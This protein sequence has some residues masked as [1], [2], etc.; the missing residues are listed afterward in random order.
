MAFSGSDY[1]NLKFLFAIAAA[2][3]AY[4]F[5]CAA[6]CGSR[7][8]N[9]PPGPPTL[10]LLG[11]LTVMPRKRLHLKFSEWAKVY[12]DVFSLKVLNQTIIVINSPTLVRELIDKRSA[13]T[14]NRPKSILA[15]MITPHNM[16]MGT[17]H[18]AN[19]TW[20]SMRKASAQ[21]LSNENMRAL[22][23]YQRA[24][25]TQLMWELAHVPEDWF[26]HM[27]RY[28]TSFALGIIYGKRGPTLSSQDVADFMDVHP[29]FIHAL[30]IGTMPPVDLFPVLTLVPER[31]ASW[32]T[33]VKNIRH[34]HE[35][36]YDRL[37]TTV[38]K[39]IA[40]GRGTDVFLEQ[41]IAKASVYGLDTREHL[42]HLG[43]VLLEGSDTCSAALQN[44]VYCLV[45]FPEVLKHAREEV[46]RVVGM[47]RAP[48]WDD[49]PKLPYTL[50]F[51]EEC[52]R[53]RP[54]GPLGLPHSMVQDE[55]ID[56]ILYPKDAVVFMNLWG[57]LHDERYFDRPD[58]FMPERFLKHPFGI[59]EGVEDDPARRPNMIFGGGRR[60][61]PGISF[62]K[63]SLEINVANLVWGFNFEPSK[64]ITGK[65]ILPSLDD[66]TT[67]VTATPKPFPVKITPRSAQHQEIIDKQFFATSEVFSLY[68]QEIDQADKS[69]N[70]SKRDIM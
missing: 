2:V 19:S 8:P 50:A 26:S 38:E 52:H 30:E 1:S 61:C 43:G 18:L 49:I 69:F 67:G 51:I 42:M 4:V 16:N 35:T 56:G 17:G 5:Y 57:M 34:L 64:D 22:G 70:Q 6:K 20:K 3:F 23:D 12:G 48:N 21:L 66:Y 11:N 33:I 46:D 62:A 37:L 32:K 60:V 59:K 65:E 14:S 55:I 29:K 7:S 24:E 10:P 9:M 47:D 36:L 31:W 58:E 27:R 45:N 41:M 54:V 13:S 25:A 53:Y 39:R 44:A 68:E 40:A 63:S 15:D 28:T